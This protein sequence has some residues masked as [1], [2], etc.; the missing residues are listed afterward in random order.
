MRDLILTDVQSFLEDDNKVVVY[1]SSNN[2][3]HINK[4]MKVECMEFDNVF[5]VELRYYKTK[6]TFAKTAILR[7]ITVSGSSKIDIDVIDE[8]DMPELLE[9]INSRKGSICF[10]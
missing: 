2:Q 3:K 4:A 1:A 10:N 9:F 5:G 6:N 8:N 7:Y